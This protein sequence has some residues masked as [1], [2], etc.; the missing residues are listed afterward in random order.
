VARTC[1]AFGRAL[2]DWQAGG[3]DPEI[4]ERYDGTKDA[5]AG[6]ELYF[7][8]H[9]RWPKSER[10][11]LRHARGRVLDVGCGAG[12][13]SIHL[14]ER[15]LDVVGIDS[16]Q[17]AVRVARARGLEQT[18]HHSAGTLGRR[19]GS[20][21]T[22]VLFGNNFGMFGTPERVR[23]TLE[24]WA[25]WTVPAARIL[26]ESTT[27]YCGGAPLLDRGHLRDNRDR[28]LMPGQLRLRICYRSWVSSWFD[29]LFVSRKEMREL[30]QGT[31]WHVHRVFGANVAEPYVALLE[32]C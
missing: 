14:Q 26:A 28:G 15:G 5:G 24:S 27:P 6:H 32:K 12:R 11:A 23:R 20:F 13:V 17:L 25:R 29:W 1:D 4:F 3:N 21:D 22:I 16:S 30:L 7:A 31:G 18:W 2:V 8:P 9:A 19:I 10:Q